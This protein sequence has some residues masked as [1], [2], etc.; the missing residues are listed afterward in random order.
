VSIH[1]LAAVDPTAKIGSHV[2][3]GPFCVIESDVVIGDA[4]I[5]ESHVIVKQ[6]TMLG[7]ENHVFD[8]AVLGGYPQHLHMPEKP[9][10]V[11]IGSGNTIR[12]NVTVHRAMEHGGVTSIGDDNLLMVNAHVAHDCRLGSHTIITNNVMLAGHVTVADKAYLSG[13]AAMHQFTRVGTL[14]MV[15]GQAHATRDVPP[16]VTVDGLS[17]LVVGL[18][19][20]GLRR[21]GFDAKDIR[22]LKEAYRLIYR[23]GFT[24]NEILKRLKCEFPDGPAAEFYRFC[25]S[26]KRGIIRERR[27]PPDA[28]IK[29]RPAAEVEPQVRAKA[30]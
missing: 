7:T 25:S 11:V 24:W 8:G 18:N 17:S 22:Q 27:L 23:G 5:L 15:G 14:A 4:C 16:F 10:R 30:G 6:A 12:E 2:K 19:Q 26:T 21:A 28:T 29:L 9:G 3:I 13:A 1:P 20:V